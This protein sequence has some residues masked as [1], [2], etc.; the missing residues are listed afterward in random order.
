[1]PQAKDGDTV[2]VHY[3]G[4]LR[5]GRVFDSSRG[6]GP[7]EFT[8]G[9]GSVI[10]GFD[11]GVKGMSP[12]ERRTVHVPATQAYGPRDEE[13][14]IALDRSQ[15]PRDFQ[16]EVGQQLR[17][18]TQDGR[19]L[20][21]LVTAVTDDQIR[22]DANHPLAGEDLTFDIELIE[23]SRESSVAEGSR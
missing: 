13:L 17:L 21:A 8:I 16:P 12:G 15:L 18:R 3:T 22:L 1:M 23:I 4:R 11:E 9:S 6:R 10:E 7:L 5:D 2:K 20:I 14:L 19:A